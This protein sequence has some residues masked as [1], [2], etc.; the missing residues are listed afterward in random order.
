MNTENLDTGLG[1][2]PVAG[3]LATRAVIGPAPGANVDDMI[4]DPSVINTDTRS[5][6]RFS[7][8]HAQ[9]FRVATVLLFIVAAAAV[10]GAIVFLVEHNKKHSA[11][12]A[13]AATHWS[14][15]HPANTGTEGTI[16]IADHVAPYYR[17]NASQELDA[18]TPISMSESN[19]AGVTTGKGLTVVVNAAGSSSNSQNLEL[20]VGKTVAYN[21]CGLGVSNCELTGTASTARMLLLRREA[22]ELALYTFKY[23]P[24]VQNV[25]SVLPPGHAANGSAVTVSVLFVR[26]ELKSLLNTPLNKTLSSYPLEVSELGLW[27]QTNEA[28]LVNTLTSEG[29]FTSQVEAQQEGG[30]LLVLDPISTQ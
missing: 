9:K 29:L 10:A 27:S 19:N 6:P 21:I 18:V 15:W 23:S 4:A 3:D 12:A 25:I 16:E 8:P 14:S 28:G 30:D 20:L 11:I 7:H 1:G 5:L 22:L 26:S 17:L 2:E 24:G 13:A